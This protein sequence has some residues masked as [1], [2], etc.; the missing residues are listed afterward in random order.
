MPN[1]NHAPYL[2]ERLRSIFRQT[3]P[4]HE[5][6][7]LDDASSDESV[8]VARRLAS[9]SPVPFRLVLNES[10][11][12]STFRQWLKGIDMAEGDLVWIA[13]SDDTCRPEMLERLVPE[14]L[15][16]EVT[17]AYCQSA[18]IGPDG[19]RYAEDYLSVTE[20]LSPTRWRYRYSVPGAVEVALAL[21]QRNTI[22]N[23]S[24][25]VFRKPGVLEER[26]DLE[27]LRLG[28]DWLFY[29]MRIRRGK[30]SYLP[31]SLNDH[32]HHDRSVRSGFERTDR[33]L[34]GA[35]VR[36]GEDLRV[37]PDPGQRDLV[38][39][40]PQLRGLLRSDERAGR[41]SGDDRASPAGL[42][43]REAP[44]RVPGSGAGDRR[45]FVSCSSP[46]AWATSRD[47]V[48]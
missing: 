46:R 1:F 15:D 45:A 18:I 16:P 34:R 9:D 31:A 13:E 11:S 24:A 6:L 2:E 40:G 22:P 23:A 39:H 38:Q 14:F 12:G 48:P 33:A 19:R 35:V 37:I 27:T 30:I 36:Q 47:S 32:R 17:L 41:A 10:N 26:K 44:R 29:A 21:S 7:F 3:Y 28:G 5:V 25:V 8:E 4:P 20:D 42:A 43:A